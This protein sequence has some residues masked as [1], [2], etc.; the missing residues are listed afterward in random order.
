MVLLLLQHRRHPCLSIWRQRHFPRQPLIPSS[1]SYTASS[2]FCTDSSSDDTAFSADTHPFTPAAPLPSPTTPL[3]FPPTSDDTASTSSPLTLLPLPP[4]LTL[5]LPLLTTLRR[6]VWLWPRGPA[7]DTPPL[8][9]Q[10]RAPRVLPVQY[11]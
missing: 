11:T 4:P 8:A 9:R 5:V 10:H 2:S 3:P 1:S 7:D 6:T